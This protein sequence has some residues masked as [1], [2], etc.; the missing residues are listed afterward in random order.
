MRF[1]LYP[2]YWVADPHLDP[3]PFN[4]GLL[5]FDI[6]EDVRIESLAE[7][8]RPGTFALGADRY[9]T[10]IREELE[11]VQYALVHRYDPRRVLENG[12]YIG[13][14]QFSQSSET[15]VRQLMALL[16]LIR[17]MRARALV[18]RGNIRDEDETFDITGYDVPP[19]HMLE[20]PEVQKLFKLRNQDCHDL[21]RYAPEFLRAM[22]GGVWKFRMAVQFHELGHFQCLDWKARCLLWASAIESLFTTNSRNHQGATVATERIK[23]FLGE[24]TSIYSPGDLTEFE[25]DPHITVGDAVNALYNVRNHLAHGDRI[26]DL[27]FLQEA[28]RGLN[29]GVIIMEV[30]VEAASFIIRSSLLKILQDRLTNHFVDASAAEAYFDS[31]DLTNSKI[32][33]RQHAAALAA[34][35]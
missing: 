29:G 27:Y 9:G 4:H 34:R 33:A 28:R 26:P 30:L 17:P 22:R 32:R 18:M 12:E 14:A 3:E 25:A 20:V 11:S 5:P 1:T 24:N 6:A 23:W 16:R 19:L 13:D 10:D 2:I 7:R 31:N 15:L 8:F 35:P 21:R